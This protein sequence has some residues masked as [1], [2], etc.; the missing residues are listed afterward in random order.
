LEIFPGDK[1][2]IIG[3]FT[4][5]TNQEVN[6]THMYKKSLSSHLKISSI[7]AMLLILDGSWKPSK[8]KTQITFENAIWISKY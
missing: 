2:K 6:N 7:L 4:K 8:Q 5:G 3:T 1:R